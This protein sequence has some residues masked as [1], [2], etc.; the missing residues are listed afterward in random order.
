MR[1]TFDVQHLQ[2]KSYW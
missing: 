2:G 1:F